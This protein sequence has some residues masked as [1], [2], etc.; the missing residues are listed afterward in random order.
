VNRAFLLFLEGL[1]LVCVTGCGGPAEPGAAPMNQAR[2]PSAGT[3]RA[4]ATDVP[5]MREP[6]RA[7]AARAEQ[8]TRIRLEWAELR[9]QPRDGE[10]D[11][12]DEAAVERTLH[13]IADEGVG[14]MILSHADGAFVQSTNQ[15]GGLVVEYHEET[16][17]FRVLRIIVGSRDEAILAFKSFLRGDREHFRGAEWTRFRL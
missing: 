4:E 17:E 1:A 8:T 9:S 11:L 16:T 2:A 10:L 6:A 14:F 15:D 13:R 3:S 7:Q 12:P 5:R